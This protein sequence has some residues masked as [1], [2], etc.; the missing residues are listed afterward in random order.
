MDKLRW[1]PHRNNQYL[2]ILVKFFSSLYFYTPYMTLYF[3]ERGFNYVQINSVWG[4]V[5]LTMFLAEIPTGIFADRFGR[6]NAI[7]AAIL[8]QLVG[9]ILFLF[10]TQYWLLI[11]DAVLAGIGFAFGSGAIEALIYDE[12][13]AANEEHRTK[14]MMGMLHGASYLGFILSFSFGGLLVPSANITYIS[15]AILVTAIAVGMGFILT[16][17]LKPEKYPI[18]PEGSPPISSQLLKDGL[19][20]LRHNTTLQ[21]LTVLSVFTVAFWDYLINLYPPHFQQIGIPDSLL[22]PILALASLAALVSSFIVHPLERKIG[23]KASLLLATLGPGL[24]YLMLFG[25]RTPV[26]GAL[27]LILFRGLDALKSPLFA[28]YQNKQI[29]SHNRATVLSII[30]MFAGAYTALMGLLIGIIAE[31][32]LTGAFLFMGCVIVFFTLSIFIAGKKE[33]ILS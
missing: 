5:V 30:N 24:M 11:L 32:S 9:E 13:K 10:I 14:K 15:T 29:S 12:L 18:Q 19:S 17:L 21:I 16:L 3:L 26:F 8:F 2:L 6:R 33:L 4:I 27:G 23:S 22:G 31:G 28:D 20:L 7:R 25:L 1:T